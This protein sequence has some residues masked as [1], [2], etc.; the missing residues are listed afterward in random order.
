M[1]KS[2]APIAQALAT[3]DD[4]L[5]QTAV[6]PRAK[7]MLLRQMQDRLEEIENKNDDSAPITTDANPADPEE[8]S[9]KKRYSDLRRYAQ[10][11]EN[12]F[13]KEITELKSQIGQLNAAQNQPLPKT[14]EEFEAWK[15]KYPDIVEFIEIIAEER[16]SAAKTQLSEELNNV[17]TKL[18][19]TEKEKAFATLKVMVPDLEGVLSSSAYKKWFEDQPQFVQE[20]L[21]T[22]DDPHQIAYYM[23]IFKQTQLPTVP[24]S[25]KEQLETLATSV[26]S[27]SISPSGNSGKYA[28]TQSQI[29]R[30]PSHEYEAKEAEIIAARNSGKIL[31][32]MSKHNTVFDT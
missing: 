29:A 12:S 31:D 25:K 5:P 27:S 23:G 20:T 32:D 13:N 14:R 10:Q 24:K 9:F 26:K 28:F 18:S 3:Q 21:N 2:N 4:E 6:K 15:A 7:D 11:K 30:M 16:A 22:S 19:E 1:T 8:S 17:K